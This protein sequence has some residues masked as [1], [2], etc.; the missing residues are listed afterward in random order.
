M[1]DLHVILILLFLSL[2]E[3]HFSYSCVTIRVFIIIKQRGGVDMSEKKTRDYGGQAVI[4]GVMFGGQRVNVTAIRRKDQSIEFFEVVREERKWLK[5]LKKIPIL[6]G[7]VGLGESAANGSKHLNFSTERYDV[8]PANDEQIESASETSK[9]VMIFG[10]AVV[11]VLSLIVGKLIFTVVPAA[12][13]SLLFDRLIPNQYVNNIVEG[14]IKLVL[15]I[16]YIMLISQTPL[17]KR[18]FQYHGAEHKVINAYEGG[19]PL[20]VST[21]QRFSRL[22]YRCGSSFIILTVII[23]VIVYSFFPYD[24][25]W[26][27]IY[28]RLILLLPVIGL[29]YEALRITNKLRDVPVLRYLGYPGLWLQLLTTKEPLDDQVEVAIA[30]FNK[31]RELDNKVTVEAI[32]ITKIS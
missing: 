2:I 8:D 19:V 11:G 17:I 3:P 1:N 30:S 6:R 24:N 4:E 12:L 20:T 31:M 28:I 9:L 16:S 18:L 7:I 14:L 13:A 23:G 29:S 21:V 32:P 10:V 15:L 26:E 5:P 27:R 22:H 25:M